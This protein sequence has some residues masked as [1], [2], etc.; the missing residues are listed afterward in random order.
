MASAVL[1]GGVVFEIGKLIFVSLRGG[2]QRFH[3]FST[4]LLDSVGDY[5]LA[6]RLQGGRVV[7]RFP[8]ALGEVI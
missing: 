4:R 7:A 5:L 3:L 8:L 2:I 6:N 1:V